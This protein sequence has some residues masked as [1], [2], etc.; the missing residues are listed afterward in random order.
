MFTMYLAGLTQLENV[1]DFER[2]RVNG[3]CENRTAHRKKKVDD[4]LPLMAAEQGI[5]LKNK[6]PWT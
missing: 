3:S 5:P 2:I 4:D 6:E 1:T